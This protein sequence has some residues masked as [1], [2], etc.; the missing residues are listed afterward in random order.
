VVGENHAAAQG[1]VG[2]KIQDRHDIR[3]IGGEGVRAVGVG[4]V[5]GDVVGGQAVEFRA[6]GRDFQHAVGD[7]AAK[8][9]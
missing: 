5:A 9:E 3:L 8:G 2:G 7:V 6:G 4:L 1:G